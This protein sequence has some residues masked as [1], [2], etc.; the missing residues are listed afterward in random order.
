MYV[1]TYIHTY[2]HTYKTSLHNDSISNL[3]FFIL[4]VNVSGKIYCSTPTK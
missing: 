2:I 1:H 4:L 3:Y